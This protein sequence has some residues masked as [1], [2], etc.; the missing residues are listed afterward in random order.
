MTFEDLDARVTELLRIKGSKK[1]GFTFGTLTSYNQDNDYY[2]TPLRIA[3]S[4]VYAGAI[5]RNVDVA[6]EIAKKIQKVADYIFVDSE[7]KIEKSN[8]G[9]N[10]VGN[11]EKALLFELEHS[12]ILTYK[13]ND[14]T[15]RA[16]DTLLRALSPNL[17]GLKVA[18]IGVGNI[19]IKLGMSL[20][21][22]GN[23]VVLFSNDR[24]HAKD[25]SHLINRVKFRSTIAAATFADSI[26]DAIKNSD[27]VIASSDKKQIISQHHI[28]QMNTSS[29]P[30]TKIMLDVGKGCFKQEVFESEAL[31]YR[32]DIGDELSAELENLIRQH[33]RIR[34]TD[35]ITIVNGL[36][37]VRKGIAGKSGDY[38]IDKV[39]NETRVIGRCDDSGN[40]IPVKSSEAESA[41]TLYRATR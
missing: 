3:S 29:R 33:D 26:D 32:V 40:L 35:G 15:V 34:N 39:E 18:I 1:L 38:I 28:N 13:G 24:N 12:E 25:V 7:K 5:V 14:L 9:K 22:R 20:V 2:L 23:D 30:E 8:Y 6:V 21:E 36:R 17:T 10:D 41:I 19:G 31:I 4:L 16:A 37:F 27:V 11:I